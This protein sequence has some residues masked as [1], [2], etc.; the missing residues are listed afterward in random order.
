MPG[1]FPDAHDLSSQ[2]NTFAHWDAPF[3]EWLEGSGRIVDYCTDLDLHQD[4]SLLD[5]Y[6]LLLCVGHDEYWSGSARDNA[7]TFLSR[8]GN[9]AFFSGDNV[10]WRVSYCDD[11]TA[12]S[13]AKV[14]PGTRDAADWNWDDNLEARPQAK[15]TGVDWTKGVHWWDGPRPSLGYTVQHSAHWAFEGTSLQDGDVLGAQAPVPL[16]GYESEGVEFGWRRGLAM[17]VP[18]GVQPDDFFILGIAQPP[19]GSGWFAAE[20]AAATMGMYSTAAGGMVFQAA[21]TDWAKTLCADEDVARVTANVLDRLGVPSVRLVGPAPTRAGKELTTV[22][23][24][25]TFYADLGRLGSNDVILDWWVSAGMLTADDL[26]ARIEAVDAP[27]TITVTAR[28]GGI[29]VGFGSRTFLPLSRIEDLQL[30]VCTLLR[31]MVMPSEPSFPLVTSTSDPVDQMGGV[32]QVHAQMICD[33]A[34]RLAN[35]AQE[36][37]TELRE[38]PPTDL[39]GDAP[40]PSPTAAAQDGRGASTV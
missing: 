8:G 39:A 28:R 25:A 20:G 35:T 30:E 17:P 33:L 14:K 19:P 29:V 5:G 34:T 24:V 22:G 1:S 15:L 32:S 27:M 13:C 36:L 38:A 26:T 11:D 4:P 18:W 23:Q 2:R 21:T 31:E 10:S 7:E 37:V 3:I 40:G 12:I 9:I 6:A 16:V